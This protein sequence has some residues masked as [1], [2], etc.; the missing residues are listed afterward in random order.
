MENVINQT[1]AQN[2]TKLAAFFSDQ[3]YKTIKD[4]EVI[5]Y[6]DEKCIKIA[7]SHGNASGFDGDIY[8]NT[9]TNK[10][11]VTFRGTEFGFDDEG[12]RDVLKTDITEFGFAE[13]PKQYDNAVELVE[14]AIK[15]LNNGYYY[16]EGLD[17]TYYFS[18]DPSNLMIVGHSLGGGLAQLVGAQEEYKNYHVETF[19]AVGAK[20]ILE[21][22]PDL[23]N[24]AANHYN[25][26]NHV[27]SSL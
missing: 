17:E 3:A 1:E 2:L 19:N 6:N 15:Y 13:K 26:V 24:E 4:G 12:Y 11:I 22:H 9:V 5:N 23:F 18:S 16:C 10:I 14:Q 8:L 27:I 25:I 21:R 20:E 7:G